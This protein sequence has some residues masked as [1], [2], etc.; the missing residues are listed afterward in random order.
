M[1]PARPELAG[2]MLSRTTPS[3]RACAIGQTRLAATRQAA[4]L[5]ASAP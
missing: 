3:A 1:V 5:C 4:M 2:P